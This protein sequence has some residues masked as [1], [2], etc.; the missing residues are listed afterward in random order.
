M[1]G[2]QPQKPVERPQTLYQTQVIDP[3]SGTRLSI[4]ALARKLSG[5]R[6][7]VVGEYH[8]HPA[9]HLLQSQ[10]QEALY[11]QNP[12]QV[13]S[14]E[15][16][17]LDTQSAV[18]AYLHNKTG[19]AELI[20]DADAW[21]NYRA[22]YRPLVEFARLHNLPVIAANA[23]AHIVRCVGRSG[24]DYLNSLP[25][26]VRAEL[27]EDPFMDTPGYRKKFDAAL[28]GGHST[29]GKLMRERMDNTYKA[30][31]LRDNTMASRIL[32]ALEA[33]PGHQIVHTTGTFHSQEHLGTVALLHKRAPGVSV[34]VISPVVWPPE[35]DK[36]PLAENRNKGDFLFF[37]QPLPEEYLS[38]E[39]RKKAM[40][41]RFRQSAK[42][43]C[44]EDSR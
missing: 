8:G 31:L 43:T 15:Q 5:V 23:P 37:V 38:D 41:A 22:S 3:A 10:I 34:A 21:D 9:A 16:F 33:Y 36:P 17:T 4:E 12:L 6:V 35:A 7:I 20:E 2:I 19:E 1:A 42:D 25:A 40:S 32:Q 29:A 11:R 14:M 27:P 26:N 39:R 18:N 13:L 24:R 28:A 30:Q 44:Q